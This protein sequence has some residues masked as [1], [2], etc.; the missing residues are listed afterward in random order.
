MKTYWKAKYMNPR[1]G[2]RG[3][4]FMTLL[5][6]ENRVDNGYYSNRSDFI[7]QAITESIKDK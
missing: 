3:S 7:N 5:T 6:W 1:D 4:V 2:V